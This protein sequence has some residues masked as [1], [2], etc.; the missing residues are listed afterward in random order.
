MK[1]PVP[2]LKPISA[3]H[4]R[5][6]PLNLLADALRDVERIFLTSCG[7]PIHKG[8]LRKSTSLHRGPWPQA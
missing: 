7:A 8:N 2:T 4:P 5:F 6:S 1:E 3:M